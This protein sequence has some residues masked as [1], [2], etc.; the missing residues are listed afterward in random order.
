MSS[1]EKDALLQRYETHETNENILREH[2]LL[3]R[4][5]QQQGEEYLLDG[6]SLSDWW[7]GLLHQLKYLS[8]SSR[9]TEV[10]GVEE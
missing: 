2:F 4:G 6:E 7:L 10:I 8:Y 5:L 9:Q 3:E 1:Q